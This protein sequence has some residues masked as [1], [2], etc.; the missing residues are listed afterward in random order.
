MK[1]GKL[2]VLS[3]FFGILIVLSLVSF[4]VAVTD[5]SDVARSVIAIIGSVF[6]FIASTIWFLYTYIYDLSSYLVKEEEK[7]DEAKEEKIEE[8]K[9]N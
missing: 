5:F 2:I 9:E 1:K 3:I 4:I 6:V 8:N 7:T